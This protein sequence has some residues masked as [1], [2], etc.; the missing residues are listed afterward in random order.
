MDKYDIIILPIV[1]GLLALLGKILFHISG[2]HKFNIRGM[3]S[4]HAAII[5]TLLLLLG[6][7]LPDSVESFSLVLFLGG[8]Y[9]SDIMLIYYGVYPDIAIDGNNLGHSVEEIIVGFII[10]FVVFFVYKKYY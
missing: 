8:L 2:R 10:A 9:L 3:P 7:K 4:G 1:S 5:F 6:S